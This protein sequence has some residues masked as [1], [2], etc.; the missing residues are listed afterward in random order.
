V[1]S[2]AAI[3]FQLKMHQ[4]SFCGLSLPGPSRRA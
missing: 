1:L 4:M 3:F 2:P